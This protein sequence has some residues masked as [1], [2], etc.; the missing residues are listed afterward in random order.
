HED[1]DAPITGVVKLLGFYPARLP[2]AR[3]VAEEVAEPVHV[4]GA[5]DVGHLGGPAGLHVAMEAIEVPELPLRP[6]GVDPFQRR[7]VFFAHARKQAALWLLSQKGFRRG[8]PQ[9]HSTIDPSFV[10]GAVSIALPSASTSRTSP[11]TL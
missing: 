8:D 9:R 3:P 7:E 2:R 6:V 10:C 4:L 1:D 11:V 5:L